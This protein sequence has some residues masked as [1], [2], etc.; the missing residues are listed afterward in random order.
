[1]SGLRPHPSNI[2]LR[3]EV[4]GNGAQDCFQSR[5]I[6]VLSRRFFAERE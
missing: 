6:L 5:E 4:A 3:E 1:M 2:R